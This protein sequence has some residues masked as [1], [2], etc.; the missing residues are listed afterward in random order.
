MDRWPPVRMPTRG[1]RLADPAPPGFGTARTQRRRGQRARRLA[2]LLCTEKEAAACVV[3]SPV[4]DADSAA[5]QERAR[6]D[7]DAR[8]SAAG[9]EHY[10]LLTY[11]D[12]A[13]LRV[14]SRSHRCQFA[15]HVPAVPGP[16]ADAPPEEGPGALLAGVHTDV[17]PACAPLA[18]RPAVPRD[19][20]SGV[21]PAA[22]FWSTLCR[23]L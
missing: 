15:I 14:A 22:S 21:C 4:L 10:P 16:R 18:A 11:S 6:L 8:R 17:P 9:H 20:S 19:G 3:E 7:C 5:I 1:D 23:T 13:A 12:V 2:T